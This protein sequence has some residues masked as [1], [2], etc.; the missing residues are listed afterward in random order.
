MRA[1]QLLDHTA[2]P[3][4]ASAARQNTDEMHERRSRPQGALGARVKGD[5]QRYQQ[6]ASMLD[7]DN[8]LLNRLLLVLPR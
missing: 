4:C 5:L 1:N 6:Y 3:V 8:I 2:A 7:F